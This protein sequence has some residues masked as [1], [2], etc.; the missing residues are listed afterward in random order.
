MKKK[1]ILNIALNR[2]M[3][4]LQKRGEIKKVCEKRRR[5]IYKNIILTKEEKEKIN[6]F[7][8]KNYGKKIPYEW[9]RLYKSY[10]GKFDEKYFPEL[11]YIP[12]FERKINP[13]YFDKTFTDKQTVSLLCQGIDVKYPKTYCYCIN[14]IYLDNDYK[15]ISFEE[16]KKR[17]EGKKLFIKPRVDSCSG[18]G[19]QVIEIKNG[20]NIKSNQKIEELL[21]EYQQNF[22]IQECLKN[23][24]VLADLHPE[25]INTFRVMTYVWNGEVKCCPV[26]LRIGQG[27]KNIDN[28][29]AGGM[30]VGVKD[31]GKLCREAY[32]EFQNR[33]TEHPDT[34]I[35]F[36]E[37]QIPQIKKIIEAAKKL[38]SK[39]L[40][41]GIISWDLSLDEDENVVMI[42]ANIRNGSIWLIQMAHG[43]GLFGEDTA[44]ILRFISNKNIYSKEI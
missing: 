29:H 5:E 33:Y 20:I 36:E 8:L 1:E 35:K 37:Y 43:C 41:V 22:L 17:L 12:D 30:F 15:I 10:T 39:I 28:A 34:K 23:H 9:H 11:L 14:G 32:T 42:E 25:S 44:E 7:Y 27:R 24:K 13:A 21:A 16:L 26:I 38:H 40:Q 31:N 18:E 4:Y 19:C 2:V 3:N 6:N